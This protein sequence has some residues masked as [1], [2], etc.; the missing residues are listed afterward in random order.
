MEKVTKVKCPK[1]II[2]G[3]PLYFEEYTGRELKRLVVDYNPPEQY[4]AMVK[5]KEKKSDIPHLEWIEPPTYCVMTLYLGPKENIEVY[6]RDEIY[7]HQQWKK[8]GL[9]AAS[10][11]YLVNVDGQED[12]LHTRG[13]G[14]WGYFIEIYDRD[15]HGKKRTQGVVINMIL[16][17]DV[18]FDDAGVLVKYFFKEEKQVEIEKSIKKK[19]FSQER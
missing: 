19:Q 4:M 7:E 8:K 18:D 6:A 3:D 11:R 17:E 9:R 16:P 14:E 5:I 12:E 13:D 15:E 1:H 2:L 10:D